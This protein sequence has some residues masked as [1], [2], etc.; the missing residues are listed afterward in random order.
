MSKLAYPKGRLLLVRDCTVDIC[1]KNNPGAVL[2]SVLLFWYDNP[3]KGDFYDAE[4]GTFT[5]CRTQEDIEQQ[6]CNQIDVKTI[7]D[8]AVPFL[9]LFGFLDIKEKMFGNLYTL[10]IRHVEDAFAALGKGAE[11]LKGFLLSSLQLEKFLI[12]LTEDQLEKTLIDKRFLLLQLEKVLIQNREISNCKR[13]RKPRSQAPLVTDFRNTEIIRDSI[14]IDTKRDSGAFAPSDFLPQEEFQISHIVFEH[15]AGNETLYYH[16]ACVDGHYGASEGMVLTA[17]GEDR[18][19]QGAICGMCQSNVH[20]APFSTSEDDNETSYHI[21]ESTIGNIVK[22]ALTLP[23][24]MPSQQ[25]PGTGALP[26]VAEPPQFGRSHGI[27][28]DQAISAPSSRNP[29]PAQADFPPAGSVASGA[30]TAQA[31]GEPEKPVQQALSTTTEGNVAQERTQEKETAKQK[32][33]RLERRRDEI[34]VLHCQLLGRNVVRSK[35][36]LEGAR[37]MAEAGS[38]DAEIT[39]TYNAYKDHTFWGPQLTLKNVAKLLDT[40]VRRI[41]GKRYADT[42]EI[43]DDDY[44]IAAALKI[45]ER[46]QAAERGV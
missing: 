19:P 30:S 45:Q 13:G 9:Q 31:T 2:L 24:K 38:T 4:K 22:P 14:E 32:K 23:S 34:I 20:L 40:T 3:H 17:V 33:A 27:T 26:S 43:A 10:D 1:L 5:V 36:E 25:T 7:H 8:V 35:D 6:A 12:E 21:A 37:L 16:S 46:R 15:C 11:Y 41:N 42:D 18:A 44:S 39:L 28:S 29:E